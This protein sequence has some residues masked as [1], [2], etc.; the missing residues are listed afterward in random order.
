LHGWTNFGEFPPFYSYDNAIGL[1]IAVG[2]IGEYLSYDSAT[3]NTYLSR[4]GG[5]TWFEIRKGSSIY[6]FGDHGG[7]IVMA[8]Y[9]VLTDTIYY[10]L[11]ECTTALVAYKFTDQPVE[12]YNIITE[13]SSVSRKFLLFGG[14][15][16]DGDLQRFV[17]GLDFSGVLSAPCRADIDY[18]PWAPNDGARECLLGRNITYRRRKPEVKCYN[19]E[20]LEPII[21]S[22]NCTCGEE[23]WECDF[24]YGRDTTDTSTPCKLTGKAPVDPPKYCPEGEIYTKTKG[25]RKVASDSCKGG[26]DHSASGPFD[27]PAGFAKTI[28]GN[29]NW[30]AAAVIVPFVVLL[31]IFAFIV[32]RSERIREKVPFIKKL[33]TWKVGYFGMNNPDSLLDK[34]EEEDGF[35]I[36]NLE[37]EDSSKTPLDMTDFNPKP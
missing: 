3:V 8:D 32:M 35:S 27:C 34:E 5:L 16:V 13:P 12:V 15:T 4:D 11:D 31:I 17:I 28:G 14:R 30:I 7:I 19:S 23:D 37:E 10:T 36:G 25:Y 29:K 21:T 26:V 33:S 9:G 24:E 6:E 18:I 1:V 22:E 2:N 20:T